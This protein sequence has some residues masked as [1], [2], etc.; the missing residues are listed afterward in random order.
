M[1]YFVW[2]FG[3]LFVCVFGIIN[4]FW[5]EY[6]EMMDKDSEWLVI[7]VVWKDCLLLWYYW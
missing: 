6:I 3:V 4:V 2:I 1:W 7:K 5:L